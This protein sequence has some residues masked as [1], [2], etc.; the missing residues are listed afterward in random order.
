MYLLATDPHECYSCKECPNPL[1]WYQDATDN[2]TN[3][4]P[5]YIDWMVNCKKLI[6]KV[7]EI[8]KELGLKTIPGDEAFFMRI[9]MEC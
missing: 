9:E 5:L 3:P 8:L 4:E 7:K 1:L 6:L 2:F